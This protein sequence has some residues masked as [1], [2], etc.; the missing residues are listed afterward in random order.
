MRTVDFI[1]NATES[2]DSTNIYL[3]LVTVLGTG[4][5]VMKK[6]DRTILALITLLVKWN[7]MEMCL[8]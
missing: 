8:F 5:T 4:Y 1:L 7:T 3:I 2:M 6:T